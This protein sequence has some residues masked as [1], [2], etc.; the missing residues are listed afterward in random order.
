MFSFVRLDGIW[1]ISRSRL[2]KP[3]KDK[4]TGI[5]YYDLNKN[6]HLDIYENPALAVEER[7]SALLS[8]MTLERKSARCLLL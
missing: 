3:K 4:K 6:G 2:Y 8:Q 5:S 1:S 7:V